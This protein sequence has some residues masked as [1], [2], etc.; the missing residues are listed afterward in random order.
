MGSRPHIFNVAVTTDVPES[1]A[2]TETLIATLPN[3]TSEFPGQS[4]VLQAWA[5]ITCGTTVTAMTLRIRRDSLTG[6]LVSEAN[7]NAGDVV[8][9]KLSTIP[10]TCA[11]P[12]GGDFGGSYVLTMQGTGEGTAAVAGASSLTAIV[13]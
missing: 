5:A 2:N 4:V 1:A 7:P 9:S 6:A 10:I 3:V 12:R 11:D 8:A 13:A